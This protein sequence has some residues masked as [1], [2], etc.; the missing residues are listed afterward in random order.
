MPHVAVDWRCEAGRTGAKGAS[1]ASCER[2]LKL[3]NLRFTVLLISTGAPPAGSGV[4]SLSSWIF[5][6]SSRRAPLPSLPFATCCLPLL[7]QKVT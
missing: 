1:G 7:V 3:W 4:F 2:R 6:E 5:I